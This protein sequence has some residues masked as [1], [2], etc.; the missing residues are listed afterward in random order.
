MKHIL[1]TSLFFLTVLGTKAQQKLEKISQSIKVTD[2]V[3]IDL[4]TN[5][6]TIEI[7][8]WNKDL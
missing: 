4:N 3:T 5:Y 7:D 1:I 2:Q 6:T 8:T